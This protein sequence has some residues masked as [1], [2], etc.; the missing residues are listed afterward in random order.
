MASKDTLRGASVGLFLAGSIM[1]GFY[2][3]QPEMI[4]YEMN[5]EDSEENID[6]SSMEEEGFTIVSEDEHAKQQKQLSKLQTK[7]DMLQNQVIQLEES[8]EEEDNHSSNHSPENSHTI[9]YSILSIEYG[10]TSQEISN[11][12][13]ILNIIENSDLFE[14]ELTE[15]EVQERIQIGQYTLNNQMSIEEIVQLITS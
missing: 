15:K 10:M 2:Y 3:L 13:L 14:Q 5:L 8:V 4:E 1:T 9:F 7:N 6:L 11:K 12:L